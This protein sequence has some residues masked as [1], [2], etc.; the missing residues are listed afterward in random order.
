MS[1]RFSKSKV[2]AVT[3]DLYAPWIP[4]TARAAFRRSPLY[5]PF[6]KLYSKTKLRCV[7]VNRFSDTQ[8]TISSVA[9]GLSNNM[10]VLRISFN[11]AR[12]GADV[13][14]APDGGNHSGTHVGTSDKPMYLINRLLN[15][16]TSPGRVFTNAMDRA[17][18]FIHEVASDVG[19]IV[20]AKLRSELPHNF[21]AR[22]AL[23]NE[24]VDY[25]LL[26]Y[27]NETV[28]ADIP[29]NVRNAIDKCIKEIHNARRNH[30]VVDDKLREFFDRD[31]WV[32]GFREQVGYF[33]GAAH[34]KETYD[35][36]SKRE[37][38]WAVG[39]E[40][41]GATITEPIEYYKTFQ[42]IPEHLRSQLMVSAAMVKMF[43]EG[44]NNRVEYAD[45]ERLIPSSNSSTPMIDAN[46]VAS[47]VFGSGG[48]WLVMD[49]V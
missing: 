26:R 34:F 35:N 39:G 32:F 9:F 7:A 20:C 13:F 37:Q 25:L 43:L 3:A 40:V 4:E 44:G 18:N 48:Y 46:A 16:N 2:M 19:N 11:G 22:G 5:L 42:S 30:Q 15:P 8:D 33:L 27:A 47:C 24:A 28:E 41:R 45:P 23:D 17:V 29:S 10:R 1:K 49:R 31:K 14:D 6:L 21:S 12:F 38:V 36:Y